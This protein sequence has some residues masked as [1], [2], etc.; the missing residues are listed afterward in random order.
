MNLT[1]METLHRG[2]SGFGGVSQYE[3]FLR[4]IVVYK[5]F[6]LHNNLFAG[7]LIIEDGILS[8]DREIY[9]H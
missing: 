1:L 2:G 8:F 4:N 9:K 7:S 5:L 3:L 6:A